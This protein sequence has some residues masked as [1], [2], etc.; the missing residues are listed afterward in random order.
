MNGVPRAASSSTTG[1]STVSTISSTNAVSAA[2]TGEYEPIPPVFGPVSPSPTRLK[3]CAGAS[4]S[5]VSPSTSAKMDTSSPSSSSS[6]TTG[7]SNAAAARK[8]A[9]SSSC[10]WQTKTPLPAASPS[11]LTTIG[12]PCS[13]I[14]VLAAAASRNRR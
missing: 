9:S 5:T 2:G 6:I 11:A 12:A 13:A 10:V 1:R 4:G 7:P 3:S 8:P 14:Y